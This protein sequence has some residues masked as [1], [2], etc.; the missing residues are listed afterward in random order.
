MI[1]VTLPAFVEFTIHFLILDLGE[2]ASAIFDKV[3]IF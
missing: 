3:A 2:S 1:F